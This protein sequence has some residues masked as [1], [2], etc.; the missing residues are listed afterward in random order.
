MELKRSIPAGCA[1]RM[2]AKI[3]HYAG[4]RVSALVHLCASCQSGK[5]ITVTLRQT[6]VRHT[7]LKTVTGRRSKK[8]TGVLPLLILI[9]ARPVT[10]VA[11]ITRL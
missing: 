9:I 2:K 5:P 3:K 4:K 1:E 10:Q 7:G 6:G 11:A 8:I